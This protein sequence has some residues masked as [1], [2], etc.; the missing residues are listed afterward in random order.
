MAIPINYYGRQAGL[1]EQLTRAMVT[2]ASADTSRADRAAEAI[3]LTEAVMK[4][5][6][7]A[8]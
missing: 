3:A 1:P 6:A 5:L 8:Q 2:P 7:G 4:H